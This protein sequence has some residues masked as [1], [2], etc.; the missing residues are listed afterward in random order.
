MLQVVSE[1]TSPIVEPRPKVLISSCRKENKTDEN[2]CKA[3]NDK[4]N[5]YV[6]KIERQMHFC[7][8]QSLSVVCNFV[9]CKH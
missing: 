5:V 1:K 6:I 8:L 4:K 7:L 9:Y 3:Q 2:H